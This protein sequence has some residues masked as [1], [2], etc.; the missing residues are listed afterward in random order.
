ME[1]IAV[2]VQKSLLLSK[3]YRPPLCPERSFLPDLAYR[4]P[5]RFKTRNNKELISF[6]NEQ[7]V[8]KEPGELIKTLLALKE[9]KSIPQNSQIN[10]KNVKPKINSI[11]YNNKHAEPRNSSSNPFIPNFIECDSNIRTN[12]TKKI[13]CWNCNKEGHS[14][15]SCSEPKTI[16]C[17][18][19]SKKDVIRPT[20]PKCSE[21]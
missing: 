7:E 20:C 3:I 6:L 16:F 21:N 2:S 10:A 12:V 8:S 4:K 18:K 5:F 11:I 14:F 17:F 9:S 13:S 15:D 1:K 19:C